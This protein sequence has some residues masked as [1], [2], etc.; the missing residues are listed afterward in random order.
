MRVCE[1]GSVCQ[2]VCEIVLV[3]K[4]CVREN[5]CMREC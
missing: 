5:V 3:R 4:E 2:S 1:R